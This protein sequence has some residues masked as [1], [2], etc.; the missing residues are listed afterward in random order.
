[1]Y[2]TPHQPY[3]PHQ[4]YGPYPPNQGSPRPCRPGYHLLRTAAMWVGIAFVAML[5]LG[6]AGWLFGMAFHLLALLVRIA[7]VTAVIAFVW[8]RITRRQRRNYD[9]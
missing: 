1:M 3:E 5:A 2:D 6:T 9:L 4:S 7:L 8:R